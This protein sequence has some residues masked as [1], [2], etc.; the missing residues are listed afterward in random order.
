MY[1]FLHG[2]VFVL[3]C[4]PP[5]LLTHG[6]CCAG[7]CGA[8]YPVSHSLE[9]APPRVFTLQLA[10]ESHSEEPSAIAATMRAVGEQVR[11]EGRLGWRARPTRTPYMCSSA[12]MH[13][14]E[15]C[16]VKS[17]TLAPHTCLPLRQVDLRQLYEGVPPGT[18]SRY[19]LRAMVCYYLRHYSAFVRLPELGERWV[20]FDDASTSA[21]GSWAE[22]R[23]RYE[24]G[25]VQPS[26]LF[27]EAAA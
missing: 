8:L 9:G 19:R 6:A 23:R 17:V 14:Y 15:S 21:V 5:R 26:V 16:S 1:V 24:G 4:D 22:V 18:A 11:S 13:H 2:R 25:R 20:M 10:W 12:Q 3:A 27:Y 7:G